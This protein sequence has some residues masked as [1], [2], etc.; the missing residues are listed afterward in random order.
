MENNILDCDTYDCQMYDGQHGCKN[1][2]VE[3]RYG[4]CQEYLSQLR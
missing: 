4:I 3:L 1:N 2:I